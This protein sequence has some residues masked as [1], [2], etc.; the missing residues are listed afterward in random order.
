MKLYK[1]IAAINSSGG[2]GIE[3]WLY[4]S[5]TKGLYYLHLASIT[6]KQSCY[7]KELDYHVMGPYPQQADAELGM[8]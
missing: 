4:T 1:N 6:E 8:T 3:N 7:E 5:V 2:G